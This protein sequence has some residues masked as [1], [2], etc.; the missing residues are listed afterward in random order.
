MVLGSQPT[1]DVTVET[2]A[3]GDEDVT[4]SP[5]SL[6]FTDSNWDDGADGDGECGRG[7]GR[8]RRHGV[9]VITHVHGGAAATTGTSESAEPVEP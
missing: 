5:E 6:T 4:V 8:G 3:S 9:T 1:G 7:R 2:A